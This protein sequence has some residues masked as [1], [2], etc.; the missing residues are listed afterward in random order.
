MFEKYAKYIM[1]NER[2]AITKILS[3]RDS[4]AD[5]RAQNDAESSAA[6]AEQN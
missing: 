4:R 5:F 1:S 2:G 3:W 6:T